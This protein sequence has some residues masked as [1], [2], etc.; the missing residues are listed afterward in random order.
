MK[1]KMFQL[2]PFF[3][4]N[5]NLGFSVYFSQIIQ[6]P[7]S[8]SKG[9]LIQETHLPI[10]CQSVYHQVLTIASYSCHTYMMY[11]KLLVT[12]FAT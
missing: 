1:H 9:K 6:S 11:I 3:F 8:D 7:F 4:L 10:N 12:D 2:L 5:L